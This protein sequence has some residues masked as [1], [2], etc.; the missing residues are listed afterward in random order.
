MVDQNAKPWLLEINAPPALALDNEIDR[1]L[2]PSLIRDILSTLSFEEYETYNTQIE[3]ER[4]RVNQER[5]YYF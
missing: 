4:I 1:K 3:N 2:K 5:N